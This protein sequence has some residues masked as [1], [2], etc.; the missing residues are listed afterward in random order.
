M[1]NSDTLSFMTTRSYAAESP[2]LVLDN[3]AEPPA[4][5]LVSHLDTVFTPEEQMEGFSPTL[6]GNERHRNQNAVRGG[7]SDANY[8]SSH[9][10]TLNDLGPRG[11]N[12]H[13]V[14]VVDGKLLITEYVEPDSF[15]TK[16]IVNL[17]AIRRLLCGLNPDSYAK[18][19]LE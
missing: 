6:V 8:F 19:T 1:G 9:L 13:A 15:L 11:G 7:L 5:L 17:N 3:H 16:A 14:E 18:K 10:P 4:V 12:A 2:H